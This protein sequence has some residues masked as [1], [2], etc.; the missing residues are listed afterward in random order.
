MDLKDILMSR[1]LSGGGS[2]GGAC[3]WNDLKDK[4]FEETYGDTLI[5]DGTFGVIDESLGIFTKISDAVPSVDDVAN[6]IVFDFGEI[7]EWSG[8]DI[9][10]FYNADGFCNVDFAFVVVPEDGYT[11]DIEGES[12]TFPEAG[13]YTLIEFTGLSVTIFGYSGF[14]TVKTIDEKFL[15]KSTDV[16]KQEVVYV[17]DRDGVTRI[18]KDEDNTEM[19]SGAELYRY[20]DEN[21]RVVVRI[22]DNES[23]DAIFM[24]TAV[25]GILYCT[26]G[27]NGKIDQRIARIAEYTP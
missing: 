9:Q 2:S 5:W 3:S 24:S 17:G 8:E 19:L 26:F 25:G 23:A 11:T 12:V 10:S 1:C 27:Y 7:I 14:A 20:I 4:P 22:S 15:P 21:K 13:V 16:V 6:G 18:F